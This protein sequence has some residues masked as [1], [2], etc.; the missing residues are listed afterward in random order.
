MLNSKNHIY[1]FLKIDICSFFINKLQEYNA[2]FGQQQLESISYTLSLIS[3]KNDDRKDKCDLLIKN[4]IL[5]CIQWC[6]KYNI[7]TNNTNGIIQ[8]T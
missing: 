7:E 6:M 5:K 3:Q 4:N 8:L 1:R 2:I